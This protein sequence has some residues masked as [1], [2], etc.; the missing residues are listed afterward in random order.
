MHLL[1]YSSGFLWHS[2]D[3]GSDPGPSSFPAWHPSAA[4]SRAAAWLRHVLLLGLPSASWTIQAQSCLRVLELLWYF[5]GEN[6]VQLSA[7]GLDKHNLC[8]EGNPYKYPAVLA[9]NPDMFWKISDQISKVQVIY[10]CLTSVSLQGCRRKDFLNVIDF[11]S[12]FLY[13]VVRNRLNSVLATRQLVYHLPASHCTRHGNL[14]QL[15]QEESRRQTGETWWR[16][17]VE[18]PEKKDT[19]CLESAQQRTRH[20]KCPI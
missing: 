15:S 20:W 12:I 2:G 3:S 19:R 14:L 11:E 4:V 6:S 13:S 7:P 5:L 17:S 1:E 9:V 16:Q 18:M 8:C 10:F